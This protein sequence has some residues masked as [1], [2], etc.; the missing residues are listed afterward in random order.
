VASSWSTVSISPTRSWR[1]VSFFCAERSRGAAQERAGLCVVAE[2][3][4]GDAAQG[5]RRRI[6]AQRDALERAQRIARRERARTGSDQRIH[7]DE[8][9]F[10]PR[11]GIQTRFHCWHICV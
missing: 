8:S 7:R 6:V 10:A 11:R 2:L 3:H 4:H 1:R 9:G 5:H